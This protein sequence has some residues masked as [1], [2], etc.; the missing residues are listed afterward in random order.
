VRTP[1][2]RGLRSVRFRVVAAVVAALGA[3]L[4]AQ[5]ALV[6][7]QQ[8]A[9]R[10]V[11]VL[12]GAWMPLSKTVAQLERDRGRIDTDIGRVLREERRPGTGD[13][14]AASIWAS[15][16]QDNLTTGLDASAHAMTLDLTPQDE[17]ALFKASGHLVRIQSSFRDYQAA[18]VSLVAAA[19]GGDRDRA[20]RLAEDLT[21]AG[22]HISEEVEQ[23]ERLVDGRIDD[24]SAAAEADRLRVTALSAGLTALASAFSLV[25]VAAVLVAL[26][27]VGRLTEQVQRLAGGDYSGR[28]DVPGNDEI[29][30]LAGEFNR[31]VDALSARDR[32]LV[33]RADELNRLSRYLGSVVDGLQ[34]A[35]FVVEGGVVTLANPAAASVFGVRRGEPPPALLVDALVPG[36]SD[37][38]DGHDRRH[39]VRTSALGPDG[40]VVV[41]TDVTDR[42]LAEERLQRSE[43]LALVGQMLAQI[44]HEVRNP[45]NALSLNTE[46]LADEVAALDPEQRTEA[47]DLLALVS[48]EIDRLT[49]VTAHYLQL[50]R[51]PR[52][53]FEAENLSNLV[54]DVARLVQPELEQAGVRLEVR[55][56]A[57]PPQLVDG[58]QIRQALLNVVRNAVE[59][60]ARHLSLDVDADPRGVRLALTDDGPGMTPQEAER[61]TDPFFSTKASGTGL[62][63]AITK[64]ILDDHGGAVVVRTNPGEG[65]C[66][67]LVLPSRPAPAVEPPDVRQHP[68]R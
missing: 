29:A 32:A 33:Q 60:G 52:P 15:Q 57:V 10:S 54:D 62:G 4:L 35:L 6:V 2:V 25:V 39:E 12:T 26:R 40:V 8:R 56:G 19:E 49:A 59:A 66:V 50:A 47:H 28:V 31:M 64:Q 67:A 14:A 3:M 68:G 5:G 11:A 43:R 30:V 36:R 27:P 16:L 45:L 34:D 41:A 21:G 22:T 9:A 48:G 46:L 17:A 63:L 58:N 23:L 18:S 7:Q 38:A 61:A 20:Q 42:K 24:L 65:A 55:C 44:T 37:L 13:G 1:R 53:T 51:R